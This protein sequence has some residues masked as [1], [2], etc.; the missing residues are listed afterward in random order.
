VRK[1]NA[2]G[3]FQL[4]ATRS[5][6]GAF[7]NVSNVQD[8]Y[9]ASTSYNEL[10]LGSF[11]FTD[12]GTNLFRFTVTGRNASSTDYDLA[13][14]YLRL[15]PTGA[16]GNQ[17]P[18]LTPLPN[19]TVNGGTSPRPVAF[20]VSDHETVESGLAISATSSN[21]SLLPLNN[22][23]IVG[24]G[25]ERLLFATPATG[26][27]GVS[28]VT[29]I[30]TDA[31]GASASNSF[32]FGAAPSTTSLIA[33]GSVWK[34]WDSATY[35]GNAWRSNSFNDTAWLSGP[36]QLGFGDGD[37]A[38]AIASNRQWTTYFR[39]AFT[40]G[41]TSGFTNLALRLLRDD[42][43]VVYVNG[44]EVFR[45]NM[46]GGAI[47]QTTPA[48]SSV[49]AADETT[50]FYSTNVNVALL[51]PG[52]NL[53]VVEVHQNSTTSSDVSFD[54]EFFGQSAAVAPS[55]S[56]ASGSGVLQLGWPAWGAGYALYSATNLTPPVTW[57][58]VTN[59]PALNNNLWR[60]AVPLGTNGQHFF[61]LQTP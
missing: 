9:A 26:N 61:H 41:D 20:A 11:T 56:A 39:H 15:T 55:L 28:I 44:T 7:V 47:S 49:P 25:P 27:S 5:P 21:P 59:E 24:G 48:S 40:A 4:A 35:P 52:P 31:G 14:D 29:V 36:S 54:L 17:S 45:S 46:P 50:T 58:P 12:A 32:V 16:D 13:L 1:N 33:K 23:S 34:Y 37:E 51:V 6:G 60:A 10:N 2:S 3:Q 8:T 38:T 18:S 42:G 57:M 53:L 30:V 19:V 43:A 22:I